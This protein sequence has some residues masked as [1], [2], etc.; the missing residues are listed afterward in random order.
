MKRGF[1][2]AVMAV[3]VACSPIARAATTDG[4]G[5]IDSWFKTVSLDRLSVGAH[6]EDGRRGITLDNDVP[7]KLLVRDYY[8]FLGYDV[9][10][11]MAVFGTLGRSQAKQENGTWGN[12]GNKWSLGLN[13]NFWHYDNDPKQMVWRLSLKGMAEYSQYESGEG[14]DQ[15]EWHEIFAALPLNYYIL[16]EKNWADWSDLH[17]ISFYAGPAISYLDGRI[18]DT[19]FSEENK[20]GLIGGVEIYVWEK[21]FVG[22]ALEYFDDV[23]VNASLH[24]HF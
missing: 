10:P 9:L 12:E 13:A 16:F 3:C 19:D 14:H 17:G 23:M 5:Q 24:Y 6:Y 7:E 22:C 2:P 8:A 1:F 18:A 21:V 15:I 11:W 20:V 4:S